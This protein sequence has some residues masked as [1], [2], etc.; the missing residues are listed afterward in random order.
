MK[1]KNRSTFQGWRLLRLPCLTR[2]AFQQPFGVDGGV[3]LRCACP[4]GFCYRKNSIPEQTPIGR[5]KKTGFET[6]LNKTI[7]RRN[8]I[9]YCNILT[10]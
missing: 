1:Q 5:K 10:G 2:F 4:A 3:E 8:D 6:C 7:W 9:V